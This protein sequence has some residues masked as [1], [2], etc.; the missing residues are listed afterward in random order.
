MTTSQTKAVKTTSS[1]RT[2][3]LTSYNTTFALLWSYILISTLTHVHHN[4]ISST[5]LFSSLEPS[6]RWIQTL[7]LLDVLHAATSLIPAPFGSTFTQVVTRVIQVWLIWFM[8][9]S[10]T[11]T[12]ARGYAFPALLLAWSTADMIRYAYLALNLHGK[13]PKWLVWL[14]Y[15]MFYALYPVGIGAEWWLMY[16]AIESAGESSMWLKRVFYFLLASY[17]PGAYSMFTYMIKQRRKTL[18]KLR[19]E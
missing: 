17:V 5:K 16:R 1:V 18:A 14:R 8:F 3:Y 6:A 15:S 11:T 9:P 19:R 10:T 13:A 4:G 2:I 7:S 12:A